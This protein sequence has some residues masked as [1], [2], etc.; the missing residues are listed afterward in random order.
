MVEHLRVTCRLTGRFHLSFHLSDV[1]IR[2]ELSWSLLPPQNS[3]V[4]ARSV[5]L[6]TFQFDAGTH[7][8]CLRVSS[9]HHQSSTNNASRHRQTSSSASLSS[10]TSA[11]VDWT[12]DIAAYVESNVRSS[13]PLFAIFPDWTAEDY[14][15]VC[16]RI[17]EAMTGAGIPLDDGLPRIYMKNGGASLNAAY[18]LRMAAETLIFGRYNQ[19]QLLLLPHQKNPSKPRPS[20]FR[21]SM[22]ITGPH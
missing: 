13:A 9:I 16:N 22:L 21:D 18:R 20:W 17:Q 5:A 15:E 4:W 7:F 12:Q 2:C 19:D 14:D 3:P 11:M 10:D 8:L 6:A 1:L